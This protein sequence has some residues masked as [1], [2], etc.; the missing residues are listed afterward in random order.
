MGF[1]MIITNSLS[2]FLLNK[3]LIIILSKISF[4]NIFNIELRRNSAKLIFITPFYYRVK[5]PKIQ[6]KIA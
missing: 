6:G 4:L 1:N 5:L 3:V 2:I